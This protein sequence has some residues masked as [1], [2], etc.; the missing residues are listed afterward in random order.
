MKVR[1]VKVG[2]SLL[3]WPPLPRALL[4]WLGSQPAAAN[5][6]IAGGGELAEAIRRA[7]QLF[8]LGEE[9]AHWL[10]V[11]A[12]GTTARLLAAL[13]RPPLPLVSSFSTLQGW[14]ARAEAKTLVLD[15]RDF[16][17]QHEQHLPGRPLPHTWDVTSDSISARLAEVLAADD[18]VLLKSADPPKAASNEELADNGYVDAYFP[19]AAASF[20]GRASCVNLRQCLTPDA[21]SPE[22]SAPSIRNS[23]TPASRG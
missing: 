22:C 21:R 1:V 10:C 4:E 2:G 20:A 3:N 18:L 12:L 6:L 11:D 16:L 9:T 17:T 5:V 15:P 7:D 23:P 8:G 13:H 14:L 19:F